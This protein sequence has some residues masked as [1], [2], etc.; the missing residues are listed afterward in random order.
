MIIFGPFVTMAVA[1]C[2]YAAVNLAGYFSG[3]YLLRRGT[4]ETPGM[5]GRVLAFLAGSWEGRTQYPVLWAIKVISTNCALEAVLAGSA[6]VAYSAAGG[7][8]GPGKLLAGGSTSSIILHLVIPFL[9]GIGTY[10]LVDEARF[11]TGRIVVENRPED[12]RDWYSFMLRWKMLLIET[13][14]LSWRQYI[15]LPPITV[16]LVFLYIHLGGWSGLVVLGPFLAFRLSIL[17]SVEQK[18]VYLDTIAALGTYMQHYHPYTRGHLKRVADMSER[19]ARE[20]KLPAETVILMPY[21][22]LLHDIGK[23]GVSDE[24]LD[25]VGKLTDEEWASIKEHPVKGAEI[26]AHLDFLNST[27]D[28]IKYH[29]KWVDGSGYPDDGAKNG[30]VPVEAAIIAVADAF[31]AMTDDRE[32]SLD[33]TC[34]SCGYQPEDGLRPDI[35]PKCNA[36]KRRVYRQPLSTDDAI[37]ELRRGSG[38]Q[39][40]PEVVKAF[41]TMVD[42][43]GIRVGGSG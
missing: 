40:K 33:W 21:A 19:L 9:V 14:P 29:H 11:V 23:V 13:V 39:F 27:V 32:M 43:E 16:L 41:L 42:R 17:R 34:D 5:F 12:T 24:I 30:G 2:S 10:F 25:K 35:C 36:P 18:Q 7:A 6:A 15:F 1:A 8:I 3:K 26:V 38:S 28:W 20:L 37:N 31:D 4:D 22:G